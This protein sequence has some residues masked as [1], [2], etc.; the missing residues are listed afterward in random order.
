M[1]IYKAINKINGKMYIGYTTTSL[2]KRIQLHK[3]K[4][5]AG[6]NYIFYCAIRKYGIE[7][8]IWKIIEKID[9]FEKL[10]KREIYWIKKLNTFKGPGYNMTEGGEGFG[11]GEN[12]P[13]YGK[14]GKDCPNYGRHPTEETLKK[15]SEKKLGENNFMYGK[16]HAEETLNKMSGENSS[17]WGKRGKDNP[18]Y[19]IKRTVEQKKAILGI[20]NPFYGKHHTKENRKKQSERVG[21]ENHPMYGKHHAEETLNKMSEKKAGERCYLAKLTWKIVKQ[22]RAEYLTGHVTQAAL[23][24]KYRINHRTVHYVVKNKTWKEKYKIN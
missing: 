15:M 20:G 1:L 24:V 17:M 12:H 2:K 13:C 3:D 23:S 4:V 10:K 7:K 8:F 21:G 9:T 22:M 16:H 5:K 14:R 19:G 18:N 6:C 11:S